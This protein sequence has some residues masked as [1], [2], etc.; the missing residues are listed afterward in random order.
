LAIS[1]IPSTAPAM[2][3]AIA[4]KAGI[5]CDEV[6]RVLTGPIR[7]NEFPLEYDDT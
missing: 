4:I 2:I 6:L 1:K 3:A 5:L 7:G